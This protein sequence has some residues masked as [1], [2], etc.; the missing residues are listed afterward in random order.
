M[1]TLKKLSASDRIKSE[2]AIR[3]V[4]EEGC[5]A[6]NRG[7]LDGYL[8]TY[9]DSE[10]TLWISGGSLARGRG[11]I[12]AAYKTRFSKPETMG[13]L[14][15]PELEIDGLTAADAFAFGR[16]ILIVD[17]KQGNGFFT[18]LLR[19]IEGAWLMVSDHSSANE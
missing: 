12:V 19:K 9:W 6:C 5:T 11:A 3:K 10:K 15:L 13:K 18:V 7:D 17:G 2:A 1:A 16:W 14:T 4:F 8:A